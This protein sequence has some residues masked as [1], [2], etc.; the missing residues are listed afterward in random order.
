MDALM[1]ADPA[2]VQ[3]CLRGP[4]ELPKFYPLFQLL[5]EV[6]VPPS[7]CCAQHCYYAATVQLLR[8][9]PCGRGW[10]LARRAGC[11]S[12]PSAASLVGPAARGAQALCCRRP[13]RPSAKRS[14]V[15]TPLSRRLAAPMA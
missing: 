11:R 15:L 7:G 1:V 9:S 10:R 2:L 4:G 13:A 12:R 14:A 3:Q 6:G 8:G 5:D